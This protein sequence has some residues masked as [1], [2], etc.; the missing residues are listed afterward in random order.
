MW[1][2]RIRNGWRGNKRIRIKGYYEASEYFGVYIWEYLE[3]IYPLLSGRPLSDKA[4]ML[5][6]TPS[7]SG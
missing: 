2:E 5:I 7:S 1:V 3:I 6:S 4:V